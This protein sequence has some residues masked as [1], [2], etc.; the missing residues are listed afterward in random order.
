MLL[1]IPICAQ[2]SIHY[3]FLSIV[4]LS[5]YPLLILYRKVLALV[6]PC[7]Y[8]YMYYITINHFIEISLRFSLKSKI[9]NPISVRV[10]P[11]T[12]AVWLLFV[13]NI[14][15]QLLIYKRDFV[16]N[17]WCLGLDVLSNSFVSVNWSPL[18]L[19]PPRSNDSPLFSIQNIS[20]APLSSFQ[21]GDHLLCFS[22]QCPHPFK[23]G[24]HFLERKEEEKL[25]Q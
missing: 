5:H 24:G 16:F 15:L 22:V 21:S 4:F 25:Q 8:I 10:H 3:I 2:S 6:L 20:M 7:D 17:C 9:F 14:L 12:L 1:R 11:T 19:T 23:L 18:S 13:L